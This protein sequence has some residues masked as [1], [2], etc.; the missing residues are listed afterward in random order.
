MFEHHD[1]RVSGL[2]FKLAMETWISIKID[3]ETGTWWGAY[4]KELNDPALA[5][6]GFFVTLPNR[7]SFGRT[8]NNRQL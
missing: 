5:L 4:D 6:W 3:F 8:I 7:Q 1:L 2:R